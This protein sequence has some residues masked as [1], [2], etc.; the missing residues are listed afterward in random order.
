MPVFERISSV[1]KDLNGATPV[2][3]P[4]ITT[5]VSGLVGNRKVPFL[6][7]MGTLSPD[8]INNTFKQKRLLIYSHKR[9][10]INRLVNI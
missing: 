7:Q 8:V 5:G 9:R 4:T 2:P 1:M 3:G 10:K 6:I